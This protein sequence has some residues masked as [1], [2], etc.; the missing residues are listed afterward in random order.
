MNGTIAV[1]VD[2]LVDY[3]PSEGRR[4]CIF[5]AELTTGGMILVH[6]VSVGKADTMHGF[7]PCTY[8]YAII[9]RRA[10]GASV[11]FVCL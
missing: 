2:V 10:Q 8:G 7:L 4:S 5:T 9:V 1:V 11:D 3:N 6:P